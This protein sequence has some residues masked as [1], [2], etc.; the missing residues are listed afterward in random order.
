[1]YADLLAARGDDDTAEDLYRKGTVNSLFAALHYARFLDARGRP[2]EA[3]DQYVQLAGIMHGA[4]V[5]REYVDM[6]ERWWAEL[7]CDQRVLRARSVPDLEPT[8]PRSLVARLRLYVDALR[9]VKASEESTQTSKAA[10]SGCP[11][12]LTLSELAA[13]LGVENANR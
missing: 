7:P 8:A 13:S 5:Q 11:D 4:G 1:V 12:G 9:R 10:A 3:L 6:M 2:E